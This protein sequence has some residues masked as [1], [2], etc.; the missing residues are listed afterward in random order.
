MRKRPLCE[1]A[2]VAAVATVFLLATA[3]LAGASTIRLSGDDQISQSFEIPVTNP[4]T[5]VSI[6]S[7]LVVNSAHLD[8]QSPDGAQV[9]APKGFLYLSMQW[10]SGPANRSYGDP[11]WGRFFSGITPLP[12]SAITYATRTHTYA[13]TRTNPIDQTA[14]TDISSDDGLVDATYFF[15]VRENNRSGTVVISQSRGVGTQYTGFVGLGPSKVEIGGPTQIPLS[16]PSKLTRSVTASP[17]PSNK[18]TTS[19]FGLRS[20]LQV[21]FVVGVVGGAILLVKKPK[22]RGE[23]EALPTDAG[24]GESTGDSVLPPPPPSETPLEVAPVMSMDASMGQVEISEEPGASQIPAEA[25]PIGGPAPAKINL[26]VQV[27][28]ALRFEP[29]LPGLS[30]PARSLLC[31]LALHRDRP[32]TSGEIQT[33]LWPMSTTTKDV[34]PRTFQNYVSEA[35]RAVGREVFPESRS[36]G[37]RLEQVSVDFEEFLE[38]ERRAALAG[39]P[40]ATALRQ[41]ALA[42][43]REHPLA[44]ETAPYF[45]WVRAEGFE[46][47]FIRSVSDLAVRT[48]LDLM[49][50]HDLEFAESALRV[51]LLVAPTSLSLWEP[52]TDLLV[53][54]G[55]RAH[56]QKHFAQAETLLLKGEVEGLKRRMH[57]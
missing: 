46:T 56:L 30:E 9:D 51:G 26:R 50:R 10:S 23:L 44:T 7:V 13:A 55:D 28:G 47:T 39:E 6:P 37:Y 3:N 20:L 12:A 15:L 22:R 8:S 45:E 29:A 52:L 41:Q 34:S 40:E 53:L 18:H 24:A 4:Q 25:T 36:V 35:R 42:L 11:L 17:P 38:L 48:G 27:L 21:L 54:R 2:L 31:Y 49:N 19:S 43:V 57:K 33:A 16:F 5:G 32:L 14:P 1:A